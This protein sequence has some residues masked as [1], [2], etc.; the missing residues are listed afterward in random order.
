MIWNASPR[1][2]AKAESA[3]TASA[4][5]PAVIAPATADGAEERTGLAAMNAL[6]QLEADLLIGRQQIRRLA[7]DQA[8]RSHG[9]VEE[10]R[11]PRG[12]RRVVVARERA[13]RQVEQAERGE[14]RD[15]LTER[16]VIGR[17]AAPERGIVHRREI[18]EDQRRGVDE[19]HRGARRER[20]RGVA[21]AQLRREQRQHRPH[22]LRW[23][24]ERVGH[25]ALDGAAGGGSA[26]DPPVITRRRSDSSMRAW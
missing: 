5:A 3:A 1:F 6:E 4:S 2:F 7:A 12:Q 15:R 11:Q 10:R 20:A 8:V 13:I 25:R 9:I 17:P 24:E 22:A 16:E 26:G 14:N 21:A 18:V 23:R 19:L